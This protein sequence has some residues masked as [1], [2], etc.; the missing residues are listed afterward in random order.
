VGFSHHPPASQVSVTNAISFTKTL[1]FV[2]NDVPGYSSV[3]EVVR[4]TLDG[5]PELL[6]RHNM[7]FAQQ[8]LVVAGPQPA[9]QTF[10]L[11]LAGGVNGHSPSIAFLGG[12]GQGSPPPATPHQVLIYLLLMKIALGSLPCPPLPLALILLL[13]AHFIIL[14]YVLCYLKISVNL[15]TFGNCV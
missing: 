5:C 10:Q 15:E 6:A 7:N 13:F 11:P 12:S 9:S 3:I 2:N 1:D 14:M 4:K 8:A